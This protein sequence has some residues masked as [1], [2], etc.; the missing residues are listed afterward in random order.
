MMTLNGWVEVPCEDSP[1]ELQNRH[2]EVSRAGV[3]VPAADYNN[4]SYVFAQVE[5]TIVHTDS[6]KDVPKAPD[7]SLN[8][9]WGMQI[10]TNAFSINA[11]KSGL[12]QFVAAKFPDSAKPNDPASTLICVY[13]VTWDPTVNPAV[14]KYDHK[15]LAKGNYNGAPYMKAGKLADFDYVN[16]AGFAFDDNLAQHKLATVV[17]FSMVASNA[18]DPQAVNQIPGLYAVVWDD[19]GLVGHWWAANGGMMG[20]IGGS[21]AEFTNGEVLTTIA[22]SNCL[23]DTSATGVT[24]PAV[25]Q[26]S[27]GNTTFVDDYSTLKNGYTAETD[28]L[29]KIR[30]SALIFPNRNLVVTQ[31]L[32]TSVNGTP[33]TCLASLKD[34]VFIKDNEADHGGVPSNSGGVPFWESPDL[35][36]LPAGAPAPQDNDVAADFQ[37]TLGQSYDIYLRVNNDFGCAD[38]SNLKVIIEGA[39]PS[40]GFA[41][42]AAITA[43]ADTNQFV[44][45]PGNPT[46]PAFGKTVIGPFTWSPPTDLSGGHKCLRAA[47]VGGN[48]SYPFTAGS[49]GPWP[50]AYLSHQIAQR[51]IQVTNGSKC[52]YSISN[53]S[54]NAANLLIGLNVTPISSLAGSTIRLTFDDNA[55]YDWYA[56]WSQ[57]A[58]RL[59]PNTLT[60]AKGTGTTPTTVLT[61]N[62]TSLALDGVSVPA[63]ASPHV[64]VDIT[65]TASPVPNV[66]ISSRLD[67]PMYHTIL[68]EN[69]GSCQA[70]QPILACLPGLTLCGVECVDLDSDPDN[71]GSCGTDC[72]S[73][74]CSAGVCQ[75]IK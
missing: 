61:L 44:S 47:V 10:N 5:S 22:A 56:I 8:D 12:V 42:W 37:V 58:T 63:G 55:T 18:A 6:E 74:P 60:V 57:Q 66:A 4:V 13:P 7:P 62:T 28:N 29:N 1:S 2:F 31:L 32:S 38:I 15:C 39:D 19:P 41:N 52:D 20:K 9:A 59:P 40:L 65:T 51:N 72:G 35:F 23:G 50:E 21:N 49:A 30:S 70:S 14:P 33:P 27:T 71:C 67:D 24:C 48:Q 3:Y 69:G 46:V 26:L 34:D 64:Y 36:I 54:A 11:N 68:L 73:F 75:I 17:Q 53:P 16:L 45:A 25:A 43:G